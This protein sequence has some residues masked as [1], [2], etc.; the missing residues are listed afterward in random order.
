MLFIVKQP[1]RHHNL[2]LELFMLLYASPTMSYALP[3]S[4]GHNEI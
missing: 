4:E 1:L 2:L 3:S